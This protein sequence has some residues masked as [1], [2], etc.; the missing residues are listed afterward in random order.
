MCGD[1]VW[2]TSSKALAGKV[3]CIDC[4]EKYTECTECHEILLACNAFRDPDNYILCEECFDAFC[5]VCSHCG[6]PQREDDIRATADG[7][8]IC[9]YCFERHY[10]E[11][12]RCDAILPIQEASDGPNGS[13]VC[14]DCRYDHVA[15]CTDCG[16]LVWW[17]DA[18]RNLCPDCFDGSVPVHTTWGRSL[19]FL[20]DSW[21][22]RLFIGAE[23]EVECEGLFHPREVCRDLTEWMRNHNV[24]DRYFIH[25]D[26]SLRNGF[27]VVSH[28]TSLNKW[29]ENRAQE[30]FRF[31][32]RAGC[33]SH[34]T[35][36]CGLHFHLSRAFFKNGLKGNKTGTSSCR[37]GGIER[38]KRFFAVARPQISTLSRRNGDFHWC[39]FEN[40]SNNDFKYGKRGPG[41]RY[42][43][44]NVTRETVE[45]RVFKG[46]LNHRTFVANLQ[47]VDAAAHFCNNGCFQPSWGEFCYFLKDSRYGHLTNYLE[48]KNLYVPTHC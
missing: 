43:A 34:D 16:I 21:E 12:E 15:R 6:S 35:S 2:V 14:A 25:S 7:G 29:K 23:I 13:A 10:F 44:V 38:L 42:M 4:A 48:R 37:A 9:R 27:E 33:R 41:T 47:F 28:P 46:T 3:V 11:C 40:Y 1:F 8:Y 26:A 22:G 17:D 18:R 32:V 45:I 24:D 36:T 5:S 39:E 30:L 19:C 31:L 20:K